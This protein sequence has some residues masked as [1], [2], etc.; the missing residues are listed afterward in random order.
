MA[1]T[2]KRKNVAILGGGCGA[3]AAAFALTEYA[4]WKD[5]FDITV[6]QLGWRLGGKGA[7][8]RN[9]DPRFGARIE[10]HGL[11]LW[12]GFYQNAFHMV[13]KCYADL[14]RPS[15]IPLSRW[16]QAFVPLDRFC[17][18]E[19][20]QGRW[21]HWSARFPR[22][23]GKPGDPAESSGSPTSE[24]LPPITAWEG[25]L[26]AVAWLRKELR[27]GPGRSGI[28]RF[29]HWLFGSRDELTARCALLHV[30]M[31]RTSV[32]FLIESKPSADAMAGEM[33]L[34]RHYLREEYLS[35]KYQLTTSLSDSIRRFRIM[36]DLVLTCSIGI[37]RDE[38]LRL[39]FDHVDGEELKAWLERHRASKE[40][41]ASA[42]VC[43]GYDY[44][45]GYRAGDIERPVQAAGTALRGSIRL[46]FGYRG[47]LFW[48]MQAGMGDVVFGPLYTVLKR[49]GVKFKFFHRV[50]ALELSQDGRR[51]EH[52]RMTEQVRPLNGEYCPLITVKRLPVW[53]ARPRFNLLEHGDELERGWRQYDLESPH[54]TWPHGMRADLEL[55]KDFD[56]IV[57]GISL[58]ALSQICA[59]LVARIGDW[60][61]MTEKVGT[62]RTMSVQLWLKHPLWSPPASVL[63]NYEQRLNTI[64]DL[65]NLLRLEDWPSPAPRAVYYFCGPMSEHPADGDATDAV[66]AHARDWLRKY[67]S[68]IMAGFDSSS[69]HDPTDGADPLDAQ[70]FRANVY[71]TERYV[72]HLPGTT[73]CRMRADGSSVANLF[74][75]GDW[76]RTGL[77]A[78]CVE[79]AVMG[80]FQAARAIAGDSRPVPGSL[81]A[82]T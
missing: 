14:R 16:E 55:G 36:A 15:S 31:L 59:D 68:Y 11:H 38:L 66:K 47:S 32:Q 13:R 61:R 51:I 5:R 76:V 48:K 2:K 1:D 28:C 43:G 24:A 19:L 80:G 50:D 60:Q 77:N 7:S 6:Y 10:E 23:A 46:I 62:V 26:E 57:L 81:D 56:L 44:V 70:Y 74:L 39:G 20:V 52:V 27:R 8:G 9:D 75:A 54:S 78:G 79:A 33:E 45:F 29:L 65:S 71:P 30:R 67:G 22:R 82:V 37:L 69:L 3:L 18:E 58:S 64:A 49:R 41:I 35:D 34:L 72:L 42:I 4:D 63:T 12:A 21:K 53:P 73:T 40:A 17:A 25:M